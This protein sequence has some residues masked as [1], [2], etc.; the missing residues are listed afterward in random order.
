MQKSWQFWRDWFMASAA[1]TFIGFIVLAGAGVMVPALMM[2]IPPGNLV[3][4]LTHALAFALMGLGVGWLQG[5]VLQKKLLLNYEWLYATVTGKG[6]G[7]F[8]GKLLADLLVSANPALLQAHYFF[9]PAVLGLVLGAAQWWVLRSRVH[10]AIW[11]IVSN[12]LVWGFIFGAVLFTYNGRWDALLNTPH[13]SAAEAQLNYCTC[14]PLLVGGYMVAQALL[15]I[16]MTWL[17]GHPKPKRSPSQ[18]RA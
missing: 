4:R 10:N 16:V 2:G 6:V 8:L 9:A 7:F 1:G 12:T 3:P 5:Y 15:G 13:L 14:L 18:V 11:W 17:I